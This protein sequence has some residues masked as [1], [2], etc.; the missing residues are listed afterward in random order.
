VIVVNVLGDFGQIEN[1][2]G[3]AIGQKPV[4]AVGRGESLEINEIIDEAI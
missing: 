1:E 2:L 4:Q 3:I